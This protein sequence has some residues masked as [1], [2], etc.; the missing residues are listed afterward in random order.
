MDSSPFSTVFIVFVCFCA[1]VKTISNIT[2]DMWWRISLGVIAFYIATFTHIHSYVS[3]TC[4]LPCLS[5]IDRQDDNKGEASKPFVADLGYR[6]SLVLMASHIPTSKY[7]IS[8]DLYSALPPPPPSSPLVVCFYD[9]G[10]T[11]SNIMADLWWQV[12]LDSLL[13]HVYTARSTQFPWYT[14]GR[15]LEQVDDIC[16]TPMCVIRGILKLFSLTYGA[17]IWNSL[18]TEF[19]EGEEWKNMSLIGLMTVRKT[20]MY[21]LELDIHYAQ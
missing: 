7:T 16:I 1:W 14:Q 12:S 19:K 3:W 20:S 6:M 2:A 9:Q 13:P 15:P 18:F 4:N 8:L 11:I 10:K 5:F 17:V 21:K